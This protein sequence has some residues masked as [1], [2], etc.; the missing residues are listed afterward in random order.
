VLVAASGAGLADT[1]SVSGQ[2]GLISMPDARIAPEGTWRTGLSFMRPYQAIWSSVAM[3]PWLEAGFRY[4]RIYH[5]PGFPDRP[6]AEDYGDYKDKSFDVKLRAFPERGP[7]PQLAL[8]LQDAGGGTGIFRG[9]YGV[10][11][12]RFGE[13]D[14]TLGYGEERFDGAFGGVRW[15]PSAAPNWSVVAEYDAYDYPNDRFAELSGA[16]RYRKEMAIGL[17]YRWGWFGAKVFSAHDNAGFNA[18]VSVPLGEREF[19]PKVNEPAPYTRINPRPTEEQWRADGAH[20]SRLARALVEQDFAD[21]SLGYHNGRLEARLTNTRISSMPRAVGRAARTL[22]SFAPLEVR[23]IRVTYAQGT[24]PVATY[25]FINMPLLQRYF[26]GMATREMLAPYVAIEYAD[27][28]QLAEEADRAETLEAFALPLP[29]SLVIERDGADI[30]AL[31]GRD[32]L[33]GS[34]YVAPSFSTYFNDPSGAFR[35]DIWLAAHYQR[36]IGRQRFLEAELRVPV[37]GDVDEVTTPSNSELPHVRTDIAEYRREGGVKLMRLAALQ[38]FHPR[39]RVYAKASA[40]VY[41]EMFSGAGGQVLYL[42]RGG[43]WAL[44][45]EAHWVRQRDFEG[46]FGHQDYRTVT[47]IASLNYRMAYGVTGTLRAG[48]FLAKDEGVRAEVK[49]RFASGWEV[50][51]WY[52]VTNGNDITSPGT[53]D[54]PYHD[55]GIFMAWQLDTLLTRDTQASA[56]LRLSPWTRDVGQMVAAPGELYSALERPVVRM[57]EQGGLARLGDRDEDYALPELGVPA[58]REWPDFLADDLRGAGRAAGEVDW[59]RST[60]VA[61]GLVLGSAL[62]DKQAFEWAEEHKDEEALKSLVRFGDALPVAAVALSGVFAFDTSR[63]QL[64]DAGLAALEASGVALL[65]STFSKYLVGRARPTAG[66]GHREFEPGEEDD[67][68][69]S[70][71]SRHT[72]VMWAAVTP[73]AKEYDLPWLYGV[74]ALTNA[75]RVGSREHW[76]SDTVAGSLLGYAL[77]HIA[78]EARRDARLGRRG[79][80]LAVMPDGVGVRWEL[81]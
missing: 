17:E 46:W 20:R 15:T 78:W 35:Y 4:T 62:L 43:R 16:A 19:V 70:F 37:Y 36:P 77:G 53:P 18:Y 71:P 24:L 47:A 69:H 41:E 79:P 66:L 67:R 33:G 31:R 68:F 22:L 61:G 6:E 44:D 58:G 29:E 27:P 74:A 75:A 40:G 7:W 26:N 42:P 73:Y 38:F 1:P 32:V 81:P 10:A 76:V 57:H 60:L 2:T 12:K 51:A 39:E 49:R 72:A 59:L 65:G 63:P 80:T 48:R 50:G 11:S 56:S 45:V 34:L 28:A 23:E 5:V 8:G 3:F 52:T 13:L 30:V 9:W 25:T 21:I 64:S 54:S 14:L 55:K